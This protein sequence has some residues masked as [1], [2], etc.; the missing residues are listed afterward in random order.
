MKKQSELWKFLN[1]TRGGLHDSAWLI[2]CRRAYRTEL[3]NNDDIKVIA[4]Q[5][6]FS[7]LLYIRNLYTSPV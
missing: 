5:A 3:E 2:H 7:S 1:D 6:T 4:K